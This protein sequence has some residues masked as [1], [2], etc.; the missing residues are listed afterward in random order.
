MSDAYLAYLDRFFRTWLPVYD[1]FTA[2]IAPAYRRAV[3][4]AGVGEGRRV[5]DLAAGTGELALR[6]ARRGAWVSAADVTAPMLAA[7]VEKARKRRLEIH[8]VRLDGRA[9]SFGD[10]SFDVVLLGFALHDM[11]RPV[12]AEILV[13]A[14]RVAREGLVILDYAP[15]GSRWLRELWRRSIGLVE[16][17]YFSGFVR[18]GGVPAALVA[19]GLPAGRRHPGFPGVAAV[20]QVPLISPPAS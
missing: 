18:D 17:A 12:R 11:P 19:A 1:L 20:W 16:T 5:L 15:P 9:L 7:A 8:P 14:A 6:C 10:D 2:S 4:L 13:E 3:T